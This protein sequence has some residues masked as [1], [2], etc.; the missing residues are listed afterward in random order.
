M[1]C[2][3]ALER[4]RTPEKDISFKIIGLFLLSQGNAH[5]TVVSSPICPR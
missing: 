4:T 3:P 2:F 1:R 5:I